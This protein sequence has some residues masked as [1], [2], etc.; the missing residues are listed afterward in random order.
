MKKRKDG[1]YVTRIIL[2]DGT[3]KDIYGTSTPEVNAKAKAIQREAETGVKLDD[4]TT[5][6]EWAEQWR[7]IY[8]SNLREHTKMNYKNAWN[9]HIRPHLDTKPLKSVLPVDVRAVMNSVSN[10]SED[11]QRKVL[12]TMRQMFDTAIQNRLMTVNPCTG[13]KITPHTSDNRIKV[14]SPVQQEELMQN[15]TD[16]RARLFCALGIYAGLRREE[17]LGLQWGDIKDGKITVNRAVTFLKNQQD[18]NHELKSKAAHRSI[19]IPSPLQDILDDTPHNSLFLITNAHGG[20][21]TLTAYRRLWE[22][23]T[24]SVDFNLHAH[25]LRH[26][27]ATSLYRAGIDLKKAQYLLGH[28]DIKMTAEIYTHI[29]DEQIDDAAEKIQ[30]IFSCQS[31]VSQTDKK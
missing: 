8:K 24:K 23:V 17:I 30:S 9:N 12:N 28:S 22:H 31:E 10:K 4:H 25:M 21:M 26:S 3:K 2:P 18:D 20:E 15:V 27:Y 13:I 6:G 16:Q 1:R 7:D 5:V 19:P 29:A 11:L 14:L